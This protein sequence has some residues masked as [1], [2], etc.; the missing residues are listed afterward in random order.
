VTIPAPPRPPTPSH[1]V[2][3]PAPAIM[4]ASDAHMVK[5]RVRQQVQPAPLPNPQGAR[6]KDYGEV[7]H[8]RQ[9]MM[10]RRQVPPSATAL[11]E[12]VRCVGSS[13]ALGLFRVWRP[14][15]ARQK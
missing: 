2:T 14:S 3:K 1:T 9:T 15:M 7:D 8:T 12:E 6:P 4:I 13:Q 11:H 10:A 5:F